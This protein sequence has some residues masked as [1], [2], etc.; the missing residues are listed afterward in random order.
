MKALLSVLAIVGF[1]VGVTVLTAPRSAECAWCPSYRCY[2]RCSADCACV[3][4][5]GSPGGMC[6]SI[7]AIPAGAVVLP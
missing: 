6:V 3:T 5:G 4:M 1:A 2:A 7:E